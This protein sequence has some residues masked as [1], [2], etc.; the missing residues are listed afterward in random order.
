[1][2]TEKAGVEEFKIRKIGLINHVKE[3][4]EETKK[5]E[6]LAKDKINIKR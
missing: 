2:L 3:I 6:N 1:M 4:M 5:Y